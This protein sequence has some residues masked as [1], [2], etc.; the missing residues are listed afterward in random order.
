[1]EWR[2]PFK[3]ESCLLYKRAP[4]RPGRKAAGTLCIHRTMAWGTKRTPSCMCKKECD[5]TKSATQ[6]ALSRFRNS[7]CLSP[8]AQELPNR[9]WQVSWLM[10]RGLSAPARTP[11]QAYGP[12]AFVLSFTNYSNG[13]CAGFSPASLLIRRPDEGRQNHAP[14]FNWLQYSMILRPCQ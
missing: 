8:L 1:M 6:K 9:A 10:A 4:H 7:V 3:V 11:S 13:R 14:L 2:L 12:M 5:I